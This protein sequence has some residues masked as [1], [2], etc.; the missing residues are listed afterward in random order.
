MNAIK[1]ITPRTK[2]LVTDCAKQ[3]WEANI[4]SRTKKVGQ[5]FSNV[6][7]LALSM[8]TKKICIYSTQFWLNF[9]IRLVLLFLSATVHTQPAPELSPHK[10]RHVPA[11]KE[12]PR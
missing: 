10:N 9:L 8:V 4:Q 7:L 5:C 3:A 11:A 2:S 6:N 1:W 12:I